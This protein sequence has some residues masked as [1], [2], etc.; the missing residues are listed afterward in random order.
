MKLGVQIEHARAPLAA[1]VTPKLDAP[2]LS[3]YV[4]LPWCVRKCPY[5]DFNSHAAPT[6]L[7]QTSYIDALLADLTHDRELAKDR[8]LI[9]IFLANVF[10]HTTST[11]SASA[12]HA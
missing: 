12:H 7:P 11:V 8:S 9:S 6:Q 10:P 1:T 5:C 3:L 2:P 4:H